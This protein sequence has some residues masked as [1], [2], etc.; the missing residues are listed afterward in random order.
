MVG[1]SQVP[2]TLAIAFLSLPHSGSEVR[3]RYEWIDNTDF[4]SG[5]QDNGGYL[6]T[7]YLPMR[8]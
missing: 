8:R 5:P 4:G 6:L 2:A 7:R 3:V 1:A